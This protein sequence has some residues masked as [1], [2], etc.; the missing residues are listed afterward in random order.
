[1]V[2]EE[3]FEIFSRDRQLHSLPVV[4]RGLPLGLINRNAL[5]DH[6]SKLFFRELYGKKPI[7]MVMEQDPL[8]VDKSL[9]LDDLSRILVEDGGRFLY[10]GFIITED[11]VYLGMGRAHD[12]MDELAKRKQAHLYHIAHHDGLTGLPNRQLFNDRLAQAVGM[13]RRTASNLGLLMLDLDRFKAVNDS[14]GHPAGDQLLVAAAERLKASVRASD[15][16]ARLG[17]DEF[18]IILPDLDSPADAGRV[19]EKI[20]LA[21]ARPFAIQGRNVEIS[22]SIGI[23]LYPGDGADADSLVTHADDALYE[24]KETRDSLCYFQPAL[25]SQ[26]QRRHEMEVELKRALERGQLSLF[27]QPQ[28]EIWSGRLAGLEALLRW[29]HPERGL[30]LPGDFIPLAERSGL[31]LSLGEWT[32]REACRQLRLWQER[33]LKAMPVAVNVSAKHFLQQGFGPW[34]LRVLSEYGLPP[35]LLE[36]ELTETVAMQ[37]GEEVRSELEMLRQAGMR[38]A[39]DDFGTGYS[40]LGTLRELPFDILKMDRS[41]ISGIARNHRD[42]AMA[43]AVLG[44]AQGLNLDVIA[45]GVENLE[46]LE[47]LK[48]ENCDQFQGYLCSP[49]L[50][51]EAMEELLGRGARF[52]GQPLK[53]FPG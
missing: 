22:S 31:I 21:L 15:T 38:L 51:A 29:K 24:A 11:G 9:S 44:L 37:A 14:L 17:G 45:E 33:G 3:V 50:E 23:S 46:Q 10:D 35:V 48:A 1:M 39:L 20:R 30:I 2:C 28:V 4:G 5:V 36:L 34:I 19:A 41:F 25:R 16:V 47:I 40:S 32:L 43:K 7:S 26:L 6:Y 13:A 12:L 49:P 53:D 27:Y 18:T 42:R 52:E 8:V